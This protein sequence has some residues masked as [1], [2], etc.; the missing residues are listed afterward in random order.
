MPHLFDPE[1]YHAELSLWEEDIQITAPMW[2]YI[3]LENL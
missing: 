1:S 2:L 3:P